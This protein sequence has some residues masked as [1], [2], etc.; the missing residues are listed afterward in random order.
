[1]TAAKYEIYTVY[2]RWLAGRARELEAAGKIEIIPIRDFP[3]DVPI[4]EDGSTEYDPRKPLAYF[5]VECRGKRSC[6]AWD[7]VVREWDKMRAEPVSA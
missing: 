7:A 3:D 6:D 2:A 5:A 4:H 1:M